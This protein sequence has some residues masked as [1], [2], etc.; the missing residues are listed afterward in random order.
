VDERTA[1][2]LLTSAEEAS[3]GIRGPDPKAAV[4]SMADADTITFALGS[5]AGSTPT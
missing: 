5:A 2:A 4:E 1:S 3:A